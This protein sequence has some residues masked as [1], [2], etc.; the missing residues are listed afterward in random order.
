MRKSVS[1]CILLVI[2]TVCRAQ[3]G[4]LSRIKQMALLDE[5]D[6]ALREAA[7][8]EDP[9]VAEASYRKAIEAYETLLGSGIRNGKL[10]YNLGNAY[11]RVGDLSRA[12]LNYRRALRLMPGNSYIRE[13]LR[14]AR[15]RVHDKIEMSG[16]RALLRSLFFWHFDTSLKSRTVAAI[17]CYVLLWGLLIV[18]VFLRWHPLRWAA[19]AAIVLTVALG[20]SCAV[21]NYT[22]G[23]SLE[24]VVTAEEVVLR[25]GNGISYEP[26]YSAPLHSGAEF[27]IVEQR[28]S[29]YHIRLSNGK[30][31]WIQASAAEVI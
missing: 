29:W 20:L 9:R 2:G 19:R 17:G 5:A 28:G 8:A 31:G 11:F 14:F 15:S 1:L 23:R 7:D 6:G 3:A 24:G 10:Y 25:K 4:E 30:S 12:I 21:E 27:S 18:G 13:N 16:K 26:K 22:R